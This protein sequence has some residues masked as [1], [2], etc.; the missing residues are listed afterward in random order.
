MKL[1]EYLEQ[2]RWFGGK[3]RTLTGV[4]PG[5]EVML[6][7]EGL[8]R[9][10]LSLAEVRYAEA[11]P[12]HY[13]LTLSKMDD[14][15]PVDAL[16]DDA[17]AR[18]LLDLIRE[19]RHLPLPGMPLRGELILE[20]RDEVA[21][22]PLVP[23][24]RRL[25]GDQSNTS[26][27]FADRVILKLLRRVEPGLHP[28]Y[29]IG[30]LL[31]AERFAWA[32]PLLG[33]LQL[34]GSSGTTLAVLHRFLPDAE[35]GWQ[36][37]VHALRDGQADHPVLHADFE[38][39][40]RRLAQL[41]LALAR[42]HTPAFQPDPLLPS[43]LQA[44]SASIIGEF[45][46][47]LALATPHLRLS[48]GFEQHQVDRLAQLAHLTEGGCAQRIHGDLHL[49]QVLARRGDWL[50]FDFEGEPARPLARRRERHS[51]L[52]DV[53]G[54]TRSLAYADWVAP[55]GEAGHPRVRALREAMLRGY[56]EAM[57]G[58]GLVPDGP[59]FNVLLDSL[60]FEKLLYELRYELQHRP[61]WV[62]IP[63]ADLLAPEP[64]PP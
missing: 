62:H 50:F 41:H 28:E 1:V 61:S 47:T 4:S 13:L 15:P 31:A 25:G 24:V 36:F 10:H 32:P 37:L 43:D 38:R 3:S 2:Q 52:R 16:R 55:G 56:R 23:D 7:G 9:F 12:E 46:V 63:A 14:G 35:D 44:L 19:E 57:S 17:F 6:P 18:A 26:L 34:E 49:G 11:A 27:V 54:L 64:L 5:T 20:H 48:A 60:E 21:E 53:A 51:P 45:G 22:L 40:G 42:P 8:E 30:R 59:A 29:E 39:L 58:S 33:A